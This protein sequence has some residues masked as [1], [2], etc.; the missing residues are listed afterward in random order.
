[1]L[2]FVRVLN[3]DEVTVLQAVEV[4]N[5]PQTHGCSFGRRK[6]MNI[7]RMIERVDEEAEV[8]DSFDCDKEVYRRT[9]DALVA[10]QRVLNRKR[11]GVFEKLDAAR[12]ACNGGVSEDRFYDGL[13]SAVEFCEHAAQKAPRDDIRALRRWLRE[14]SSPNYHWFKF[15]TG[16]GWPDSKID[17]VVRDL[18]GIISIKAGGYGCYRDVW[19]PPHVYENIVRPAIKDPLHR[20][21][22]RVKDAR[23]C[24]ALNYIASRTAELRER[25]GARYRPEFTRPEICREAEIPL[26]PLCEFSQ[27]MTGLE[28]VLARVER[29]TSFSTQ[30]KKKRTY[31]VNYEL[32]SWYLPLEHQRMLAVTKAESAFSR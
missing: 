3:E 9:K 23:Q 8:Y 31:M 29:H 21:T 13:Q 17:R 4:F 6:G 16:I 7:A 19:I 5:H 30:W 12:Q 10:F 32:P 11:H 24:D 26:L 2:E 22:V 25:Y 20:A 18:Q 1:M 14:K 28:G 27:L 15:K